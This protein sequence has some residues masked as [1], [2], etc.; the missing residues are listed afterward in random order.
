MRPGQTRYPLPPPHRPP[1]NP[2]PPTHPPPTPQKRRNGGWWRPPSSAL[3]PSSAGNKNQTEEEEETEE[4]GDGG[5]EDEEEEEVNRTRTR[6]KR[7]EGQAAEKGNH[8]RRP[9]KLSGIPRIPGIPQ[10]PTLGSNTGDGAS[11]ASLNVHRLSEPTPEARFESRQ[12]CKHALEKESR[13]SSPASYG[14]RPPVAEIGNRVVD[15]RRRRRHQKRVPVGLGRSLR[16]SPSVSSI[17][18]ILSGIRAPGAARVTR[19]RGRK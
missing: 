14:I 7:G 1:F 3:P 18:S 2:P 4:K 15:K 11:P 5:G 6:R 9:N 19:G 17:S 16:E 12:L 13:E 8:R 10:C